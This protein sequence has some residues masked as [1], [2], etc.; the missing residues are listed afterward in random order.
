MMNIMNS[1]IDT[2]KGNISS[3]QAISIC[4]VFNFSLAI[5]IWTASDT[6]STRVG[7][8]SYKIY[9]QMCQSIILLTCSI[10]YSNK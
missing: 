4:I 1:L 5:Y 10:F 8:K 7:K 9:K 3:S 2:K 6:E